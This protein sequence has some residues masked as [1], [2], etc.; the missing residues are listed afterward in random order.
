MTPACTAI[1]DPPPVTHGVSHRDTRDAVR[2]VMREVSAPDTATATGTI[3]PNAVIQLIGPLRDAQLAECVFAAAGAADWLPT[4][5]PPWS[6]SGASRACIVRCG[7]LLAGRGTPLLA[8]AGRLTADYIIANRI[9]RAARGV[10]QRLPAPVACRLLVA[11]IRAHAW[12]FAGSARFRGTCRNADCLHVDWQPAL[13]GRAGAVPCL[14]L[15]CGG[16]PAVVRG[17]GLAA[18]AGCRDRLRGQ[19]RRRLPLR[20]RL[21]PIAGA[22]RQ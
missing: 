17:P 21:A 16:I 14:L 15:A 10:L 1:I 20:D 4:R 2:D 5:H 13:R 22:R 11:A 9:P 18:I 19:R 7:T 12:T 6:T 8:E 3:G